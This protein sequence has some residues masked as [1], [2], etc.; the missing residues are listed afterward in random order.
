ML[1]RVN[2]SKLEG[3]IRFDDSIHR[4]TRDL[5]FE[6]WGEFLVA[7]RKDNLEIYRD[8]VSSSRMLPIL[9]SQ[10]RLLHFSVRQAKNGQRDANILPT[11]FHSSLQ[12]QS[13]R[14]TRLLT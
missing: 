3:F 9:D 11:S 2:Y 5:H 1:V 6:D 14:C 8:H 4:T 12:G 7:W 10:F 13:F